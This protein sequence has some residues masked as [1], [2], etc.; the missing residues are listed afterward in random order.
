M[1]SGIALRGSVVRFG[2]VLR[3]S[4]VYDPSLRGSSS[5]LGGDHKGSEQSKDGRYGTV[6]VRRI[7]GFMQ[8]AMRC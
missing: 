2:V 3:D 5:A 8:A 4:M 6:E 1:V 7:L